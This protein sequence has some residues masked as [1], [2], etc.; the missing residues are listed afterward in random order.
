M[1]VS[2]QKKYEEMLLSF[3]DVISLWKDLF[4]R[5]TKGQTQSSELIINDIP[6]KQLSQCC[7]DLVEFFKILVSH[8]KTEV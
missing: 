3:P 4:N 1:R 7:G 6:Y 5:L 2:R 8:L